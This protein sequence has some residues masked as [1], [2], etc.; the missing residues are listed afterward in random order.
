MDL[1]NC[2]RTAALDIM[3][4]VYKEL[5]ASCRFILCVCT[6]VVSQTVKLT[7]FLIP[8]NHL[9]QKSPLEQTLTLALESKA[10]YMRLGIFIPPPHPPKNII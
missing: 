9:Q 3:H 5:W 2:L 6:I 4:K 8:F 7:S 1:C 10:G